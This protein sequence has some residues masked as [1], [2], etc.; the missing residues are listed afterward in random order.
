MKLARILRVSNPLSPRMPRKVTGTGATDRISGSKHD[1]EQLVGR[2][3][4][5]RSIRRLMAKSPTDPLSRDIVNEFTNNPN[6][7]YD[8][9]RAPGSVQ[10]KKVSRAKTGNTS[11]THQK[12]FKPNRQTL[13][14]GKTLRRKQF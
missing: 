1:P 7:K 11:G 9:S 8:P 13:F 5:K 4:S 6:P 14:G 12:V 10:V 3:K 2:T